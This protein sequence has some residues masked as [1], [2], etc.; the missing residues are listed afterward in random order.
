MILLIESVLSSLKACCTDV[1][2]IP[3]TLC[4]LG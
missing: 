4:H 1:E 3:G 2:Q